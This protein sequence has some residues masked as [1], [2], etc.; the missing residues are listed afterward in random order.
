[1]KVKILTYPRSGSRFTARLLKSL[2]RK[3]EQEHLGE[4]GTVSWRHAVESYD[5]DIVLHQVRNPLAA[6]T[7]TSTASSRSLK[8]IARNTGLQWTGDEVLRFCLRAYPLWHKLIVE[9]RPQWR[10]QIEA[11]NQPEVWE[12][13]CSR[14]QVSGEWVDMGPQ[15][16]HSRAA[17]YGEICTW[18]QLMDLDSKAATQVKELSKEYGY[19]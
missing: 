2:G 4:E 6:I 7:S 12:E 5:A 19:A 10:Y 17:H 1:M 18:D 14:L 16:R 15:A 3:V 9:N 13:F 11:L 8:Y